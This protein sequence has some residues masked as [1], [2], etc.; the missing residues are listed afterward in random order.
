MNKTIWPAAITLALMASCVRTPPLTPTPSPSALYVG[1]PM[2]LA[3]DDAGRVVGFSSLGDDA[4]T[5]VST[6]SGTVTIKPIPHV[7]NEVTSRDVGWFKGLPQIVI[8]PDAACTSVADDQGI[9]VVFS[10]FGEPLALVR[11][12]DGNPVLKTVSVASDKVASSDKPWLQHPKA[13][14]PTVGTDNEDSE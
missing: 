11:D 1:Q 14:V 9:L 3:S 2:L 10:V 6:E 13:F 5:F 7:K 12:N 8:T 4:W